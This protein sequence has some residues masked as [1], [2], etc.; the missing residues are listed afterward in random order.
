M[1]EPSEWEKTRR[2]AEADLVR[3]RS[4]TDVE[5]E[6]YLERLYND[7]RVEYGDREATRVTENERKDIF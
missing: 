4:M 2:A 7:L 5:K 3:R 6:A 1:A